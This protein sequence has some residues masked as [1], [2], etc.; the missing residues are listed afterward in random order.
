[1][2]RTGPR[3]VGARA[4]RW[5]EGM[6]DARLALQLEADRLMKRSTLARAGLALCIVISTGA[7]K[8][9]TVDA[10]VATVG[11]E[12]ILYSE[13]LAEIQGEL[14]DF[15]R[16]AQSPEAFDR[17]ADTLLQSALEQAIEGKLLFREAQLL[18]VEIDD[19]RVEARVDALRKLY[20]TNEAFL[21]ELDAAGETLTEFRERQYKRLMARSVYASKLRILEADVVVDE[22]GLSR[23]YD[24]H[25]EDFRR[26]ERV[27]VRQIF[28]PVG[29]APEARAKTRARIDLI[30]EELNAGAAFDAL[31][32]RYSKAPGA[33][34][35]GVIGWQQR[36]D[37][38]AV[39]EEAV[40]AL[41]AGGVSDV[42]ETEG[43]VH[44]MKVDERQEAGIAPLDKLRMEIEPL[45]R[46][47]AASERYRKWIKEL[48]KRSRV[49]IF[50]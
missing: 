18:G 19:E 45:L 25:R 20:P 34:Q 41:P 49:R 32:K 42:I 8:A 36:G 1:M 3:Y 46:S 24:T 7:A 14:N 43:G 10:I 23:Y 29:S 15:R 33:D 11:S 6:N 44:I 35:G 22:A 16:D 39:L 47:Q 38:V 12:V 5:A 9:E 40:F 30:R 13:L 37:L 17:L 2:A 28:I 26:K 27:R 48:H 50:L 31:A 4:A 21:S